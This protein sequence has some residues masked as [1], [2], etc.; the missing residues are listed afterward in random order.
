MYLSYN[1]TM[2]GMTAEAI[3]HADEAMALRQGGRDPIVLANMG[4]VYARNGG[5]VRARELLQEILGIAQGGE[6]DPVNVAQLYCGL[7]N[8]E[9]AFAWLEKAY[10]QRSGLC[11]YLK[12]Y[13]GTFFDS[14][15]ADPRYA[16][17]L[18]RIGSEP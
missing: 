1:F 16:G 11:L 10:A 13:S 18:K 2:Q 15:S 3:A 14:V 8:H 6:L 17:L 9:Q 12:A 4:W 7:G 5:E